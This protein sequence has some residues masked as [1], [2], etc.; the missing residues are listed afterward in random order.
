MI[1]RIYA[2]FC[3]ILY[4]LATALLLLPYL[5][6]FLHSYLIISVC[7]GVVFAIVGLFIQCV[8]LRCPDCGRSSTLPQWS[9]NR[10]YHCIRCGK[11]F[12]YDK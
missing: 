9:K 1:K 8:L 10:T 4:I 3:I 12:T 5:L 6:N 7:L 11:P 2:H